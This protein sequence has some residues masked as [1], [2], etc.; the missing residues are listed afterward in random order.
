MTTRDLES[1][2]SKPFQLV[3]PPD[4]HRR[5]ESINK[6]QAL[7]A[8]HVEGVAKGYSLGCFIY[9]AGGLGKTYTALETLKRLG[10]SYQLVNSRITGRG[11]IDQLAEYPNDTL[12][13]DD[14]ESLF[15]EPN[16]IGV[17]RAAMEGNDSCRNTGERV[18][19]WRSFNTNI[20]VSFTGGIIALANSLPDK[21]PEVKAML[22]RIECLELK[23]NSLEIAAK[24]RDIALNDHESSLSLAERGEIVEYVIDQA[25]R[26]GKPL[27]LRMFKNSCNL[28]LQHQA[29]DSSL[30]WQD[31]VK[32]Y[33]RS[34]PGVL[35]PVESLTKRQATKAREL[36]LVGRIIELPLDEKLAQWEACTG[37][38]QAAM[39]HRIGEYKERLERESE[40]DCE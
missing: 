20:V 17:L 10:V 39:Y 40:D 31:L 5:L 15:R 30:Q 25:N 24:M 27:N 8:D 2:E 19:Q 38:K 33:V 4:H 16:A 28:Y 12:I 32:A 14:V 11:L 26:I 37:K 21:N 6:K 35:G 18:V 7:L 29:G 22:T 1:R 3:L 9:G 34:E 23:A 36:E 13:L